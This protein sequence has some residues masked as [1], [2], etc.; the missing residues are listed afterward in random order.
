MGNDME[1]VQCPFK[2]FIYIHK[3]ADTDTVHSIICILT[4]CL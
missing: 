2:K 4:H 1:I 3:D